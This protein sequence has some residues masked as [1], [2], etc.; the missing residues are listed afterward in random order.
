MCACFV[1]TTKTIVGGMM[2]LC[3]IV[4]RVSQVVGSCVVGP[5]GATLARPKADLTMPEAR[6]DG[7]VPN[8]RSE[9]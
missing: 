6:Q 9:P 7:V 5:L 2:A 1:R 3:E 8:Q 4:R